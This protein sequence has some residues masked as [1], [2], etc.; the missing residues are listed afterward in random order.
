MTTQL[1]F[2]DTQFNV[3]THNNQIWLTSK[4]LAEALGYKSVKSISNLYTQ[5]KSEFSAKMSEVIESVTS[6]NLK[7]SARIFSLR[8]AHLIAMFA[9]TAIAKEFRRWVL[10]ILD[11]GIEQ[12]PKKEENRSTFPFP[13]V[14]NGRLLIEFDKDGLVSSQKVLRDDI[15]VGPMETFEWLQDRAGFMVVRKDVV[16]N[17]GKA[18]G[19][20]LAS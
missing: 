8:G 14:K 7:K 12:Q 19:K 9:R 10:D 20:M 11:Q 2:H 13:I 6:G 17:F 1:A 4:E 15:I 3:V 5:N 16:E 18:F